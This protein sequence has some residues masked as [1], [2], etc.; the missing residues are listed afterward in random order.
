M[1]PVGEHAQKGKIRR[2]H[3]GP[4]C[5]MRANRAHFAAFQLQIVD[6]LAKRVEDA[7]I[8]PEVMGSDHCPV[9]VEMSTRA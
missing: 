6:A 5:N 2:D 3:R 7:F 1:I 4:W 9:G 8:R